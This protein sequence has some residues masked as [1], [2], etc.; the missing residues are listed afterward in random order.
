[1]IRKFDL[2]SFAKRLDKLVLDSKI[3][4]DTAIT[5]ASCLNLI[6]MSCEKIDGKSLKD[7]LMKKAKTKNDLMKYVAALR[8]YENEVL[9]QPRS[10]LFGE[11][12]I[13]LFNYFK[14]KLPVI[15]D[16]F[17]HS[18]DSLERKI[19]ALRN[20][21][22]KYAL[23]LQ[24]RSGLRIKEISELEPDDFT[25]EDGKIS[26]IVKNGKG[27]KQR[28]VE[29]LEDNYLYSKLQEYIQEYR[30]NSTD[31]KLFY[32]RAYLKRKANELDIETHDLRRINSQDRV[33]AEMAKGKKREEAQEFCKEQLGHE[34]ISTTRIYLRYRYNK[35]A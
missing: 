1:M 2:D 34:K 25:F 14:D 12:E 23:R 17:K 4:K 28:M 27:Q 20:K 29:V 8:K 35:K 21:K 7:Y 6:N 31:D 30:Q 33:K 11:P 18:K 26:V 3:T 5:Y 13:E 22:L 24:I 19:S 15:K 16:E 9:R 32:S 10:I